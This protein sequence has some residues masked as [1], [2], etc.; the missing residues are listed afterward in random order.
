[1]FSNGNVDISAS[2]ANAAASLPRLQLL[3]TSEQLAI[4][5]YIRRAQY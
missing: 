3:V 1:M 2:S 4:D 5:A